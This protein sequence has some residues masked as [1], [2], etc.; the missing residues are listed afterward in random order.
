MQKWIKKGGMFPPYYFGISVRT[1]IHNA[2]KWKAQ[3]Q[4]I[5]DIK[6]KIHEFHLKNRE[7]SKITLI[8]ESLL[9]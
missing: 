7:K 5:L 6:T 3:A 2:Q 8:K 4:I 9:P 1:D